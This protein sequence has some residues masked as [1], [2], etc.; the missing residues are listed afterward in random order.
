MIVYR[1]YMYYIIN[2]IVC[3]NKEKAVQC[4]YNKDVLSCKE[5]GERYNG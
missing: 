2:I 5:N 3:K 4:F 1:Y